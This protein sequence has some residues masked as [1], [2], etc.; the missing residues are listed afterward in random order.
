MSFS[1]SP[2]TPC[3]TVT[4]LGTSKRKKHCCNPKVYFSVHVFCKALDNAVS[5]QESVVEK[6][7][8]VVLKSII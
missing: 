3:P 8:K 6:E 4:L 1:T 2:S 5:L 7:G